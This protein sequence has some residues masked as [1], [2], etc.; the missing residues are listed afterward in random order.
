MITAD[1]FETKRTEIDSAAPALVELAIAERTDRV[2]VTAT[3]RETTPEEA[4]VAATI[5]TAKDL[6]ARAEPAL[7]RVLE[8]VPGLQVTRYGRPGSL[9]QLFGRG[10]QRTAT[11]LMIDGVPI[12]DPGGEFNLAGFSTTGIDRVEV[13]RGPESALFGADAASGVV[14]LFTRRGDPEDRLPH[15]SASYERGSFQTDR[16]AADLAGGF[17]QRFDYALAAAQFH[18]VGE[19]ATTTSATLRARPTWV[20]ASRRKRRCA[21]FIVRSIQ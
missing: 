13:V 3:R 2:V 11:L 17:G 14:Q 5:L 1:G 10:G 20:S 8:D 21:A 4:G 12:N 18:T 9:T 19:Y 7:A 15:G 16:W 6:E